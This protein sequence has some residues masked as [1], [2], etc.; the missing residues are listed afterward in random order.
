MLVQVGRTYRVRDRIHRDLGSVEAESVTADLIEGTFRPGPD[1]PSVSG[2][3]RAFEE[4]VELQALSVVD[5][6][7]P[8]IAKLG[9]TLWSEAADGSLP[10]DDVQIYRGGE[11]SCRPASPGRGGQ[12]PSPAVSARPAM[13]LP[14][15]GQ[16]QRPTH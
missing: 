12:G 13:T 2:L 9:L 16:P 4:A 11:M 1:Y 8:E 5:R 15:E 14:P 10:V 6:L 3:F 7:D